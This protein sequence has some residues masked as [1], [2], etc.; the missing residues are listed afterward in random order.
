MTDNALSTG[1]QQETATVTV[2][3][4]NRNGL[5]ARPSSVLAETALKFGDTSLTIRRGD[6]EV[7]A[8]HII[9]G[10]GE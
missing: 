9:I 6:L 1:E 3:V 8:H 5:H 7:D 2:K 10:V 4:L